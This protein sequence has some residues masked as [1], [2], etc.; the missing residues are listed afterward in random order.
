MHS[1]CRTHARRHSGDCKF[2]KGSRGYDNN[3]PREWLATR[4]GRAK[5]AH[6]A[7]LNCFEALPLFIAAVFVAM[8]MKVSPALVDGLAI[9]FI[10]ARVAFVWSYLNDRATL[11]SI[12]WIA[13]MLCNIAL[14]IAA[15]LAK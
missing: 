3:N 12:V 4:E 5:R 6:A 8:W 11:R 1:D 13:A 10:L 9:A 7:H 2:G 14:F 15:A